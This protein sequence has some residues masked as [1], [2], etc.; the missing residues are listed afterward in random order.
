MESVI[1]ELQI[2]VLESPCDT[3]DQPQ[4]PDLYRDMITLKLK[5]YG[6]EYPYG[7]LAV[8]GSDLIST[9]L[10]LCKKNREEGRLRPVMGIR[11]TSH[12]KARVHY[13]KFPG[14]ALLEQAQAYEHVEAL[15]DVMRSADARGVELFYLG[16]LTIDPEERTNKAQSRMYRELLTTMLVNYHRQIPGCELM[17]GGTMRFKIDDYMRGIGYRP[18]QLKDRELGSIH[19]HHLA[20]EEVLPMHLR[21]FSFEARQT[22]E[23]WDELWQNR[24]WIESPKKDINVV[25]AKRAG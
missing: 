1:D 7:V 10:L 5:G 20:G 11:W 22:A 4:V 25:P 16:S 8:D 24:I 6:C 2:V 14:M 12:V 17:A 23:K 9:H 21:Q 19:V 3:W 13:L 15:R 18:L